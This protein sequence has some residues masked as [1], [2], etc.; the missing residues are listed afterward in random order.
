ML[1]TIKV[2]LLTSQEQHDD[3]LKTMER[4][5]EACNYISDVAWS[6]RTFG[7]IRLQKILYY[8]VRERFGLSAQMVVRAVSKVSESYK[9]DRSVKHTF[10]SHGA[11]AY[12]HRN[13]TIKGADRV[14]I[15]TLNGRTL[16]PMVYGDYRPLDQTR[17][18]GQADL[19][20]FDGVFYLML[21]VDIPEEKQI[22]NPD[23]ILGVDLGVTNLATTNDG[24]QF[25]GEKCE[26]VRKRY[27]ALK[28]RLQS[29]GTWDAKKHLK[30]IS[31]RERRFK[32]DTNHCI[33][34]QIVET[35]QGTNRA[36][37]LEDLKGIQPGSTVSKPLRS[38][39]GKWAFY[40][41]A[42]F[43]QYKAQLLG[44]PVVF[45]DPR[46]TSQQ[47]SVCGFVSKE[48]RKSQSEF[49]CLECGHSENADINAAKNIA[50][51]AAVNQPIALHSSN[52]VEER[53]KGK[54]TPLGGG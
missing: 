28:A 1:L 52:Q 46:Y 12:D 49:V 11:V 7:K 38:A 20:Y 37:A 8:E 43:I 9:I 50:L 18:R 13:L 14:S 22:E 41:L 3:L 2:K 39:L 32:K 44:V 5:N 34:K 6:N 40:E 17:I 26:A 31:R 51:R 53:W 29:V 35:A 42:S 47:C 4:F 24:V 45:V 30:R 36:I 16:V 21:V 10:K 33:S 54:P 48:N 23:G 19:I 27:S 25:S 15:L